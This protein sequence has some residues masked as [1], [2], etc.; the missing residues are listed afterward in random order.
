MTRE[1]HIDLGVLSPVAGS[2]R[3]ESHIGDSTVRADLE[4]AECWLQTGR[5]AATNKDARTLTDQAISDVEADPTSTAGY[6]RCF[7]FKSPSYLVSTL[8]AARR[9]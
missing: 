9:S 7:T 8:H 1:V 3:I 4:A 2:A 5:I 6:E